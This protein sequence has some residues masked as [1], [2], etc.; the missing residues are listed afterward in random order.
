[1]VGK[2]R[3]GRIT[4][5]N[6]KPIHPSFKGHTPIVVLTKSSEYGSLGPYELKDEN[7]II[8]ENAWQFK[9]LYP[10]VPKS[11]QTY[12]RWDPTV[13]W[14]HPQEIHY[15]KETQQPTDEY[16]AWREKGMHN[17][18]AVRYPVG[19]TKHKAL[20]ICVVTDDGRCLGIK[21]GREEVYLGTYARLVKQQ[22]QFTELHTRLQNGENLL[23]IEVDG[24]HQESLGYYK[25]TY[26]VDDK[27]IVDDTMLA[28]KKNIEIMLGD[29][30]HSFGHGY[31]L[32]MALF[33]WA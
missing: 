27:F 17:K 25:E 30:K 22:P 2:I 1:M 10:W 32:A 23:I 14:D 8:M 20:C 21:E 7:G 16:W 19:N 24:P 5:K 33:G 26:G 3:V 28:T 11:R 29:P 15:N 13:I 31:C 6:G 9:K 12:S 4:Y 18:W